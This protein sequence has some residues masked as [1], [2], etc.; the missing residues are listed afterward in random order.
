MMRPATIFCLLI[1]STASEAA[2]TKAPPPPQLYIRADAEYLEWGYIEKK[3]DKAD[4]KS[5]YFRRCNE[6]EPIVVERDKLSPTSGSC[7]PNGPGW[8][9]TIDTID[10]SGN[11][12][13]FTT[14]GDQINITANM[15]KKYPDINVMIG[16]SL[17]G[18]STDQPSNLYA[19]EQ[20]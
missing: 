4:G 5:V 19:V 12:I 7:A 17:G 8:V 15:L 3:S 18:I 1:V 16:T 20:Q 11:A 13:V 2:D 9:G 14:K 6:S 10:T